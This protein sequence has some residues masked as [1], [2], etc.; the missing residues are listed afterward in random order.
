MTCSDC[1]NLSFYNNSAFPPITTRGQ[2]NGG[3]GYKKIGPS[4]RGACSMHSDRTVNCHTG[5]KHSASWTP[6]KRGL[7]HPLVDVLDRYIHPSIHVLT[8]SSSHQSTQPSIHLS[9]YL[10]INST[11]RPS[12]YL[13]ILLF[14]TLTTQFLFLPYT[15]PPLQPLHAPALRV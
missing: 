9:S 5:I 12:I 10:S 11:I 1:L 7:H 15:H 8:H 14:I 2:S 13:F 6:G 4:G 3:P